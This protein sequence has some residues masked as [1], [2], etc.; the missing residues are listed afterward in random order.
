MFQIHIVMF[1]LY[2]NLSHCDF[3]TFQECFVLWAFDFTPEILQLQCGNMNVFTQT[4]CFFFKIFF[5]HLLV[6]ALQRK[7]MCIISLSSLDVV[8]LSLINAESSMGTGYL[9][10]VS[11]IRGFKM[12]FGLQLEEWMHYCRIA[13]MPPSAIT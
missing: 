1:S 11:H 10:L 6:C 9:C 2:F 3:R 13:L 8:C 7:E 12:R 4:T 5:K